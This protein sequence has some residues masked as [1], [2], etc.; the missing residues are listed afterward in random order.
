M[1]YE[2]DTTQHLH[3]LDGRPLTGTSSIGDVLAKPLTWWASG[4]AVTKF[5]W[6]NPKYNEPAEV[7]V[8][9][10][11]G[12]EMVKELDIEGYRKLLDE[13]YRSHYTQLRESAK[14]GTDLHAELERF[15]KDEISG[16]RP[17]DAS[18]YDDKIH[19][20]IRW[21]DDEVKKFLWS[22]AHCYDEDLWVG[23][24]CD[25]GA[26]LNDGTIAVI[27]FKSAKEAYTTHF[28]QVAG[29][30]IQI[31]RNGLYS[32]DGNHWKNLDGKVGALI[33]VPF[34]AKEVVPVI[35]TNVEDYKT[36]FRNAVSLYRLLG[37]EKKE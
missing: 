16:R 35:K 17:E 18:A 29:Y 11:R 36:G 34:G 23:G 10:R 6:L 21:A 8:A 30:A 4:L 2:F 32:Q 15:V 1:K 22:E 24:I 20:F 31:E 12:Y 9:L 28:I 7:E 13:A 19:P 5:G 25:A 26:V 14:K 3:L 37:L 33:V 27:D